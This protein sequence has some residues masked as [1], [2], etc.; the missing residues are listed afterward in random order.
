MTTW[1]LVANSAEAYLYYSD[2]LRVDGLHL[3]SKHCHPDSRKKITDLVSDRPGHYQT[4]VGAHSS[5][6]KG[7]PKEVAAEHFAIE[8][9]KELKNGFDNNK[10]KDLVIVAPG[11]FASLLTKHYKSLT[12]K[13]ITKDYTKYK[14]KRLTVAIK[15]ALFI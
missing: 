4:D 5:Y 11:H 14:I 1:V 15:E 12:A 7:N 6:A 3:I 2:N 9:A 13:Q 8:L 10:Y